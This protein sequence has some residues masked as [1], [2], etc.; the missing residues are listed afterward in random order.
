M[1]AMHDSA[2]AR[3]L[4]RFAVVGL[5]ST[6]LY[7][8]MLLALAGTGL[9]VWLLTTACYAASMVFNYLAQARYTFRA[10]AG[11]WSGVI[12]YAVMHA[13]AM[14]FNAAAMTG[15]T[16]QG[17][18]LLAAQVP[19]TGILTLS[20]FLLSRYWVFPGTD[21]LRRDPIEQ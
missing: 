14:V 16:G 11:S 18:P 19:V 3:R 5:A 10:R 17:W 4:V 13:A 1:H 2:E 15:L 6:A 7:F 20:T 9:P 12:R 8:A 21:A